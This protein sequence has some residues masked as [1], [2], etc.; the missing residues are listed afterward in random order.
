MTITTLLVGF[1]AVVA[2]ICFVHGLTRTAQYLA[3]DEEA[4]RT[5]ICGFMFLVPLL[6]VLIIWKL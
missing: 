4:Y 6:L 5:V 1:C 3:E 2:A